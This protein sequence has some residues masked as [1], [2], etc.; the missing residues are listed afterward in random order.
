M[1]RVG[2][3]LACVDF[4]DMT[5]PVVDRAAHLAEKG[6]RRLHLLHVAAPEPELAGYDRDPLSGWTRD[7]R[8]EELRDEHRHLREIAGRLEAQGFDVLPLVVMGHTADTIIEEARRI[9]AGVVVVGSHGHGGL[10]HLLLGSVAAQLEKHSPVP[11][12][13]VAH[14]NRRVGAAH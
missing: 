2:E 11:V 14:P 5:Q 7:D 8:A 6:E 13:I 10:H 1:I 9:G 12:D 3:V 4:S